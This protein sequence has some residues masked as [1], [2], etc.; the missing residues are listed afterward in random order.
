MSFNLKS[1][2]EKVASPKADLP[3]PTPEMIEWFEKR[4]KMHIEL[5]RKYAE[6]IEQVD[7]AYKGLR[8][9]T[10]IHDDSKWEEPERLPY[11]FISW[12]YHCKDTGE[13]FENPAGLDGLMNTATHHHV[14]SNSHHPEFHSPKKTDLINRDD[15][16]KPPKEQ[17][18]ATKMPS[19]D[20]A[21][22]VADWAAMSEEK[23]G[24]V[25]G[26]ADKNVNIRWKF[27]DDQVE[28]IY[29]VI[30]LLEGKA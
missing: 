7:D 18:D 25:R 3:E 21:E 8:K 5:V 22:M 20:L 30:G 12:K 16:D 15:R 27:D 10:D 2:I 9:I 19:M 11:I 6:K 29:H 1:H 28:E 13:K 4:T 14:T 23:G 26:W 17:V 24:T